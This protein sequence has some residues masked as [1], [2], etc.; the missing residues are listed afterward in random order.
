MLTAPDLDALSWKPVWLNDFLIFCASNSL[1]VDFVSCHPY[2]TNWALDSHN[3]GRKLTRGADATRTDLT[4]LRA[5][6]DQSAYP[7]G[8]PAPAA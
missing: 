5:L 4:T 7:S 6:V 1:P 8:T 3:Q 2:P